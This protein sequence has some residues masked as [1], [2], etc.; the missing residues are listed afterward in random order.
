MALRTPGDCTLAPSSRSDPAEDFH[1]GRWPSFYEQA[2]IVVSWRKQANLVE[3]S[4]A[5]VG[6]VRVEVG[7]EQDIG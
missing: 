6:E 5:A 3:E 2:K 4:E 7:V 1:V